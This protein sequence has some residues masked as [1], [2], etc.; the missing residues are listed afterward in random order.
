MDSLLNSGTDLDLAYAFVRELS[1][2][3]NAQNRYHAV[4]LRTVFHLPCLKNNKELSDFIPLRLY[5]HDKAFFVAFDQPQRLM[6]W[7]QLDHAEQQDIHI[8]TLSGQELI[9]SLSPHVYLMINPGTPYYFE[10][11]PEHINYLKKT[12]EVLTEQLTL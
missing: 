11:S 7:L 1:E 2:D 9:Q 6:N 8:M 3:I 10:I 5:H 4:L 12:I